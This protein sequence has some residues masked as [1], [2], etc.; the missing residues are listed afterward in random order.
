MDSEY[1]YVLT[2][3]ALDDID[4]ILRYL[5]EVLSN[6]QAA[7]KLFYEISETIDRILA[8][9]Q[10][11]SPVINPYLKRNDLRNLPLRNYLMYY[12]I[13]G[14]RKTVYILRVVY[15]HRDMGDILR[16]LNQ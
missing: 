1:N 16:R 5:S 8:F 2:E 9:P 6:P 15:S 11:G 12:R 4:E 10:S 7:G 13:D 14:E 3:K